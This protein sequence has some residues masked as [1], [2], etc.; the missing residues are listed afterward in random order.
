[1]WMKAPYLRA[2]T[3]RLALQAVGVPLAGA[4][5]G[6]PEGADGDVLHSQRG[7]HQEQQGLPGA[8]HPSAPAYILNTGER[9]REREIL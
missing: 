5:Q 8:L 9:E 3:F 1:M 4:R 7:T 2:P 6:F